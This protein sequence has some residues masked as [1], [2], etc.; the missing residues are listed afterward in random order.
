[1]TTIQTY[2]YD[3]RVEVLFWDPAIFTTRTREVYAR[4]VKLYQG[5]DNPIQFVGKNQDQKPINF[6]GYTVQAYLQDIIEQ[7]TVA[8]I[9]VIWTD[10]TKGRGSFVFNRTLVNSLKYR[11]YQLTF[12]T[13]DS[14]TNIERPMYGDHDYTVPIEVQVEDIFFSS[15]LPTVQQGGIIIDGGTI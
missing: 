8:I 12:K 4:T 1:M 11:R 13:T 9:P 6:T 2:L 10:I 3:N 7:V 14:V 15:S 5:V